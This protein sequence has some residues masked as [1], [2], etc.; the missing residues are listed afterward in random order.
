MFLDSAF[1]KVPNSSKI[2]VKIVSSVFMCVN[3]IHY[4]FKSKYFLVLSRYSRYNFKQSFQV[5][6]WLSWDQ[7]PRLEQVNWTICFLLQH[8]RVGT[9][10]IR[11]HR[12]IF[13]LSI[14]FLKSIETC[15]L[16]A[17]NFLFKTRLRY[18]FSGSVPVKTW[19]Q[20]WP[21]CRHTGAPGCS[22]S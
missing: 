19:G 3:N 9:I 13:S 21:P 2:H 17:L 1:L 12:M 5:I 14:L 20:S 11:K 7:F 10:I 16:S 6:K 22:G 18:F 15:S 4:T 8:I